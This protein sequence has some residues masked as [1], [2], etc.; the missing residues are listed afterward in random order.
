METLTGPD[1]AASRRAAKA[2]AGIAGNGPKEAASAH[3]SLN[4]RLWAKKYWILLVA[5]LA[6]GATALSFA[7]NPVLYRSTVILYLAD[8]VVDQKASLYVPENS[9]GITR[10]QH[11]AASSDMVDHLIRT[12]GLVQHYGID[13]LAPLPLEQASA[14]LTDNI[15]VQ[16]L[17]K[18][19]ISITVQDRDRT[20]ASLLV[21]NLYAELR[22]MTE[23]Q[24]EAYLSRIIILYRQVIE[25]T[26]HETSLRMAELSGLADKMGSLASM[27][28]DVA[29]SSLV[30]DLDLRLMEIIAELSSAN[31]ELVEVEKNFEIASGVMAKEHFPDL[32]LIRRGMIDL[33]TRPWQVIF[34]SIVGAMALGGLLVTLVLVVWIKNGHEVNDYFKGPA[35][36]MPRQ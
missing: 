7:F 24:T 3:P 2:V 30:P 21:N 26:Q 20:M 31:R 13:T 35:P 15:L 25:N 6:G 12:F 36:A 33:T 17:D 29:G 23:R 28:G 10:L 22:A 5:L 16:I 18:N 34:L 1:V 4:D 8:P 9:P 32:V 27:G 11:A 14:L 19:T